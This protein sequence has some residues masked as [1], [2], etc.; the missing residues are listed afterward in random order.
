VYWRIVESRRING[1]PRPVPVL[2]LGNADTLLARLRAEDEIRVRSKS[3]GAVAA[4]WALASELGIAAAIDRRLI[5]SGRR[6]REQ[7][8]ASDP[9]RRPPRTNDGLSV[10]RSLALVAIGRA[11]HP[12]SKRGFSEWA[13]STT[14][15][16]LAGV[17]VER[18]TSQHFWDQ[19]DQLPIEYL[20]ATEREIV[21]TALEQFHLPLDLL[22]YDATN[23][24]TFI[25]ST[26]R[27]TVLPSRGHNKQ[28]RDDLRQIG[29][30]LLCT[31][32]HGIPLWHQTYEGKVTDTKSFEVALPAVRQRLV[33]WQISLDE[34]TVVY[35][36]GNVSQDNQESV[37][38]S[39]LHYLTGLTVA[40]QKDLVAEANQKLEPVVLSSGETVMAYRDKRTIWKKCRTVV[41]LVSEQLRDGQIRG[42]LQ[43]VETAQRWLSQL[44]D[45]LKRGKQKRNRAAI[46]RDIENRLKGR[47]H[48]RDV[49]HYQLVGEDPQLA[50]TYDFSQDSLDK[51][52]KEVLGRLVLIT[53]RHDWP[54]SEIIESYR[55][56]AAIEAVFAH[57]KDPAHIALRPQFHW[58]DQ[59]LH[60]HVFTCIQGHLL[61]RLLA[62]KAERAGAT[63]RSQ[64]KLLDTLEGIRRAIILRAAGPKRK[65]RVLTRLEDVGPEVS[66]LLPALGIT[67]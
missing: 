8:T 54:T 30:A 45:T 26:N 36:K 5:A 55:S 7:E 41:V 16:E 37:D 22:L 52:A 14:L 23:F 46:E 4:L 63:V 20:E 17:D 44:A 9:V 64:E 2:Y 1:K 58:T 29:V 39:G 6:L 66:S 57:M 43:H 19:M 67:C 25:S 60:V 32:K 51:L 18:L 24:F 21:G 31:R 42:I 61:A 62:L 11:A 12:T 53:D 3:H 10:G 34:L 27:R 49:L 47:Q 15:G 56:Q 13:A 28:K 59:K 50:L 35:D 48:L 40:S 38:G 33:D 65:P